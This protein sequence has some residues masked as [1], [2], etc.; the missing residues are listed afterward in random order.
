MSN[1]SYCR[2]ENTYGDLSDCVDALEE[3]GLEDL[4]D[5][6]KKFAEKIKDLCK[7]YL[8]LTET[9]EENAEI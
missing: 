6:E 8:E 3:S 9:Q 5:R 4:S 7:E 2:F 1:M